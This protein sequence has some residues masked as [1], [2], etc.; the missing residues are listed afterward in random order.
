MEGETNMVNTDHKIVPTV[1][2]DGVAGNVGEDN[3]D[4]KFWMRQPSILF[5]EFCI[6]PCR[7]NSFVQNMN[8]ISTLT[9]VIGAVLLLFGFQPNYVVLGVFIVLVLIAAFVNLRF[10]NK[11]GF[12]K[13][14][15]Y[16]DDDFI[17]TNVTPLYAEEW[18]LDP[19]AY[20]LVTAVADDGRDFTEPVY[21]KKYGMEPPLAPYRQ[22]LTRTNLLPSDEAEVSL[23]SGGATGAR[24]FANDA[25]LRHDLSHRENTMRMY[26]K[27]NNRRYRSLGYDTISPFTSF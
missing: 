6:F 24:T 27:I 21:G 2:D 11:E 26:K 22:Y 13:T 15:H 10:K 3:E 5:K 7:D 1:L 12:A 18:H 17:Q 20:E 14:G 19:P 25:F 4:K 8:C 9:V 16:L 23:F